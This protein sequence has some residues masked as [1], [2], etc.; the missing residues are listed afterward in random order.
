V[1]QLNTKPV[2][3]EE[4]IQA[5]AQNDLNKVKELVDKGVDINYVGN[6][7]YACLHGASISGYAE[8]VEFALKSNASPNIVSKDS[9]FTPLHFAAQEGHKEIVQL[10]ID[11]QADVNA[12]DAYGNS[13]LWRA[14]NKE[15]IGLLLIQH[16]ADM[17]QENNYDKS[18]ANSPAMAYQYLKQL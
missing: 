14:G 15:E 4:L 7:G 5:T 11:H 10:L 6:V 13:P 2:M 18:P 9:G 8:I 1:Q 3:E 16:G 12:K 17:H